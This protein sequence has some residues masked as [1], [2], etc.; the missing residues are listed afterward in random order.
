[1]LASGGAPERAASSERAARA[2]VCSPPN[3]SARFETGAKL[4]HFRPCGQ[5][6]FHDP[7]GGWLKAGG[8]VYE[9]AP[10][11]SPPAEVGDRLGGRAFLVECAP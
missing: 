3:A 2:G 7:A 4:T 11:G 1:M 6:P 10:V 5:V 9:M 8:Y